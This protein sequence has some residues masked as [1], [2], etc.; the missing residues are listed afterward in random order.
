MGGGGQGGYGQYII[1]YLGK[2]ILEIRPLSLELLSNLE[3]AVRDRDNSEDKEV[4]VAGDNRED[5]E[6]KADGDNR[7]V[8]A[9]RVGDAIQNK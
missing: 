1:T 2:E 5:K 4:K 8:K 9:V 7:E 3:E 6:D